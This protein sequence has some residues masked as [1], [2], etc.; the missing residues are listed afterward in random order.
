LLL[1]RAQGTDFADAKTD[2][3]NIGTSVAV[4]DTAT[5]QS[6]TYHILGAWD[7]DASRNIISY[8]AALAQALLNKRVGDTVEVNSD[9]G[10]RQLRIE[11]IEKVP[12]EILRTL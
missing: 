3:V 10:K 1:A 5:G 7:S 11:R 4:T 6:T 9:T 12:D 2:A 8:P